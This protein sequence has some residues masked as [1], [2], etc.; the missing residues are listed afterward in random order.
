MKRQK[1]FESQL[2]VCTHPWQHTINPH[3]PLQPT[4]SD[5]LLLDDQLISLLIH[6]VTGLQ[7]PHPH[8]TILTSWNQF[9]QIKCFKT[10]KS[11]KKEVTMIILIEL[12]TSHN[13]YA[14][15]LKTSVRT[16]TWH[17]HNWVTNNLGVKTPD[18]VLMALHNSNFIVSMIHF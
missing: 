17:N 11:Y 8:M 15:L 13:I 9:T 3:P 7:S 5:H 16:P 12:S 18:P 1:I 6:L 10:E 2:H 14:A 4:Q